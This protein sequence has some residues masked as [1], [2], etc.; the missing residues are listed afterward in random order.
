MRIA[1]IGEMKNAIGKARDRLLR[2]LENNVSMDLRDRFMG[3]EG[4][5]RIISIKKGRTS[6]IF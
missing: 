5:H 4:V 6:K 1:R 2:K 3:C